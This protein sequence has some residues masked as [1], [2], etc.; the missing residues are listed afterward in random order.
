MWRA[1]ISPGQP[2]A[3]KASGRAYWSRARGMVFS[4]AA[5]PPPPAGRT[6]QVWVVTSAPAPISA[7]LI[8][9]DTRRSRQRGVCH[10]AGHPAAV[11]VAVTLEPAGGV[12]SPTGPKVLVGTV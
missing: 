9:P 11:A 6:Y 2:D 8:E 12:P 3:P 5:L 10:A 1:S 7:G 4:A